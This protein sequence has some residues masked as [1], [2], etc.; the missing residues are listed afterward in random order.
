MPLVCLFVWSC[1]AETATDHL[2]R[3]AK[4]YSQLKSFQI[5]SLSERFVDG[6]GPSTSIV[7]VLYALPP[8]KARIETKT[9]GNAV[10]SIMIS[11]GRTVTEY[12]TRRNEFTVVPAKRIPVSFDPDRG[13]GWGE[14]LYDT[15]AK[16]I[17]TATIRAREAIQIGSESKQCIVVDVVYKGH[18][19]KFSFWI[20][21]D[22]KGL[23]LRR[24][25]TFMRDGVAETMVS[26]ARA[27]TVDDHLADDIFEFFPPSN[28]KEVQLPDIRLLKN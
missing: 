17:G 25:V 28:A 22:E 19:S 18:I 8:H 11:N 21:D 13:I 14:M 1:V 24:V 20:S 16:R 6:R 3:A 10:Q 4:T 27:V 7:L 12:R 5:E 2:K 23:I 26:T 9:T 15:V